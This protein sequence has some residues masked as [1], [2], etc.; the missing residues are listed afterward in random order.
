MS[1]ADGVIRIQEAKAAEAAKVGT[2]KRP[3]FDSSGKDDDDPS[4]RAF[5]REKDMSISS[6]ITN[7]QRREVINKAADFGSRFTSGKFL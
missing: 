3:Q 1:V 7:A 6:T 5:D 4:S 2:S